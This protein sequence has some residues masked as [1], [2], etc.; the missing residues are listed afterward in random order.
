M[1]QLNATLGERSPERATRILS[2]LLVAYNLLLAGMWISLWPRRSEAPW[3]ALAHVAAVGAVAL[4]ARRQRERPK[5]LLLVDLLPLLLLG[6]FWAELRPLFPLLHS[7][8]LDARI[9]ALEQSVLGL[10]V[11]AVWWHA[12][13]WLRGAMELLYFGYFPGELLILGYVAWRMEAAAFRELLLRGV[14]TYLVCD[15]IYLA[16]PT[17]GPRAVQAGLEANAAGHAGGVFQ[18][19]NDALRNFGDSPGTAFPSSHVAG[20]L[21]VA[22]AAR[23]TGNRLFGNVMTALGAGVSVATVYTQNHYLLDALAGAVLAVALQYAL[24]PALLGATRAA[25]ELEPAPARALNATEH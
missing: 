6:A 17:L 2:A 19:M 21:T 25:A 12:M 23:A 13:P 7:S 15:T 22:I 16:I 20:I 14:L 3:L 4:A 8:T 24:V 18:F 1:M 10:N 9:V 5:R 11:H